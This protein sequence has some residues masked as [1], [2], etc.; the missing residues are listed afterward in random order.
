MLYKGIFKRLFPFLLTFAAGLFLASFFVSIALPAL[1]RSDRGVRRFGEFRR[2]QVEND[3]L[4]ME[5]E[6]MRREMEFH[7]L[8]PAHLNLPEVP[9]VTLDAP[10]PPP[11]PR[12]P[13]FR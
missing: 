11:P 5:I 8:G 9:P 12:A 10:V 6:A 4:R 7:N 1:P 2:L 13:R 3:R